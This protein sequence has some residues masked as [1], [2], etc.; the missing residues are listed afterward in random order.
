MLMAVNCDNLHWCGVLLDFTKDAYYI[1]NPN[2][3]LEETRATQKFAMRC[4]AP[5]FPVGPRYSFS[6]VMSLTQLDSYH[7]GAYVLM[8]F[9]LYVNG[10]DVRMADYDN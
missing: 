3:S 2:Y 9:D 1:F 10:R 7:C 5:L 6:L 4:L 8:W